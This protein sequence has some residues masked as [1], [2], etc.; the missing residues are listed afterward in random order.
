M[1]IGIIVSINTNSSLLYLK[2][3]KFFEIINFLRALAPLVI[4]VILSLYLLINIKNL[5]FFKNRN[6]HLNIICIC[7]LAYTLISTFG[8]FL[9]NDQFFFD[10]I[11]WN[12][13]YLNVLIILYLGSKFF[14]YKFLKD[15]LLITLLF[16]FC[17]YVSI[18]FMTFK[19]SIILSLKNIYQST[20]LG[21]ETYIFGQGLPRTSGVARALFFLFIIHLSLLCFKKNYFYGKIQSINMLQKNYFR[22]LRERLRA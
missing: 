22:K 11:W 15:I 21:P 5:N 17:F 3:Y 14:G 20:L 19:E 6:I 1:W 7:I 8:L 9:N 18:A 2:S 16:I 12:I 13:S 4:F 10:R